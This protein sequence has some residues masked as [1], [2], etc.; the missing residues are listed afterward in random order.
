MDWTLERLRGAV[1]PKGPLVIVVM[2]GI[3]VGAGDE[4]DA[5]ARAHT[6]TLDRLRALHP[7]R[8]L[9]AH[10][11]AVG[12][13]DDSDMGNSE[14]GHNA[15]G[16]GRVFDQGAKLVNNAI[17][18]GSLF[19][20]ETWI[21]LTRGCLDRG[22]P[23][24]LIGLLSTGNVHSHIDHLIALVREAA[25]LGIREVYIHPLTDGRDVTDG[26]AVD[27]VRQI[28]AVLGEYDGLKGQR[29]RV[30]SGG[31]RMFVTMDRYNADWRIVERGWN[32]HVHG[33][34]ARYRRALDAV[35][36]LR[37]KMEKPSDQFIPPF[38]VVDE[39]DA[40]VGPIRDGASV[41][42]FNF[43]GDRA[44]QISRAFEDDSFPYF[45]RGT[46]PKADYAGMMQYDGDFHIPK[47][48]LVSPPKIDRTFGEYL[49]RNS[50]RQ[51]ACSETQKYG[52]VTYF[53][54]GNRG[55]KFDDSME[56]Y[57]EIKS[58][59]VPFEQ[60]P[61]M[62]AAEITDAAV[63]AMRGRAK[64]GLIRLNYAN[65]DMV[66]HT[67]SI[68]SSILAV[69]AVDLSLARL[70]PEVARRKGIAIVTADH[71][72]ADDMCERNKD[73]S[74]VIDGETGRPKARSSHSL[75]PVP[76]FVVD[77]GAPDRWKLR[78]DLREAGLA[79][80]AAT[81]MQILGF[82]APADYEPSLLA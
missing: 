71:G 28:E 44:I 13:P 37:A 62:K 64:Y 79:N 72:N 18:D 80:I 54:N 67:G 4:A 8:T 1:P 9:R 29:Y 40:P 52:H 11:T 57:K 27:F 10:G 43:R 53:W 26:T 47:S 70:L 30:A 14:V 41:V 69:E 25:R 24:H 63:R 73:G 56:D 61:W 31:G 60:R 20:G 49:A 5:V 81:A 38:V 17:A 48:F 78:N 45:K 23:L 68:Q 16:A 39:N 33:E 42:F 58:D 76:F 35:Q 51:F 7:Y 15:I 65:G 32:A 77:E 21:R 55:G 19:R 6:P 36:E 75:N 74:F 82:R 59:R 50:V 22:A 3:G 2:D 12:L 46:R 66:G 34:G